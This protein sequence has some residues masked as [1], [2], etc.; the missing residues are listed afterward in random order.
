MTPLL[1]AQARLR[2]PVAVRDLAEDI[3]HDVWLTALPTLEQDAGGYAP[4]PRALLRRLSM[5]VL[6]RV[7]EV[8][9]QHLSSGPLEPFDGSRAG[10]SAIV[11]DTASVATRVGR[12][13]LSRLL[14]AALTELDEVTRNVV[15]LRVVEQMANGEVARRFG[16]SDSGASRRYQNGVERL[17]ELL[18]DEWFDE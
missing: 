1:V 3:V 4:A 13:D 18:G 12:G 15:V 14:F 9:R 6:R 2:L 7:N 11:D 10:A 5:H 8:V 16:M 17:R